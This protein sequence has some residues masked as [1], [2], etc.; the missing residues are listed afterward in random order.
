MRIVWIHHSHAG[1]IH[2]NEHSVDVEHL[3]LVNDLKVTDREHVED[4]DEAG[5]LLPRGRRDKRTIEFCGLRKAS[6]PDEPE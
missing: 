6:S 2:R 4:D 5:V 3:H 1:F